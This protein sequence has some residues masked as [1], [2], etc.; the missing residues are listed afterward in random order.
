MEQTGLYKHEMGY[1]TAGLIQSICRGTGGTLGELELLII[2]NGTVII[3]FKDQHLP[4]SHPQNAG[5]I[6]ALPRL[7]ENHCPDFSHWV[8]KGFSRLANSICLSTLF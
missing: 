5:A 3:S 4:H 7:N 1:W 6:Q 2:K 8:A